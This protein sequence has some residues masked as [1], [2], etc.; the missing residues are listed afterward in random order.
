MKLLWALFSS[1]HVKWRRQVNV[2][3]RSMGAIS[4]SRS[5]L[6]RQLRH[7]SGVGNDT[8]RPLYVVIIIS[9]A[10]SRLVWM[11]ERLLQRWASENRLKLCT[12][13]IFITSFQ[14]L[15]CSYIIIRDCCFL[16]MHG[17]FMLVFI[18][19]SILCNMKMTY[20]IQN[21]VGVVSERYNSSYEN[22]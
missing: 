16:E 2:S 7:H 15:I 12:K 10:V 1:C 3:S 8:S 18:N 13:E 17:F 19:A 21:T 6:H 11:R 9:L 14:Y 5:C 4:S 22:L 20:N